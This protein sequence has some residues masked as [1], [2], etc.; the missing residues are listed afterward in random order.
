MRDGMASVTSTLEKTPPKRDTLIRALLV[1]GAALLGI[2]VLMMRSA[3]QSPTFNPLLRNVGP[4]LTLTGAILVA[5]GVVV[6][7]LHG[8]RMTAWL[9]AIPSIVFLFLVVI[10]P[11]LYAFGVSTIQW[12][13]QV[14]EQRFLLFDNYRALLATA[15][16]WGAL[17]NTLI[18]A[19]FAVMLEFLIGIGLAVLFVDRFPGRSLFL[20]LLILPLMV[21]PVVV[22]QTWRML[23]DARFGPVNDLLT[24]LAG[25]PVNTLWL[26]NPQAAIPALI[27]TDVW[28]WTPFVFLI[29][30]AGLLAVNPELYEAAAIDGASGRQIFWR[31]TLPVVRPVLMVAL[32]LRLFDALKIFDIVH[33]LTQGGPGNSTETYSYYLYQNGVAFG[34]FG[35]TAAGSILFMVLTVVAA[36]L[37]IRRIGDL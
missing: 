23:W 6:H 35:Y 1:I 18:I 29:A 8:W 19:V 13:V 33:I 15:R 36:S 37:L 7:R 22:G 27:I 14:P 9:W 28:Q 16:F 4:L 31:V 5:Q 12:D 32:L 17:R 26:A 2:G 11:T 21:A 34:R 10:F 25:Q 20:T 3:G 24:R 30:L